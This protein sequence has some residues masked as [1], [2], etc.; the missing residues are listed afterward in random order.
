MG[1]TVDDHDPIFTMF[2][3][4]PK[5]CPQT[6]RNSCNSQCCGVGGGGVGVHNFFSENTVL[7]F[8]LLSLAS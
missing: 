8:P 1:K 3:L 2:N 4:D 6:S 5:N 7:I